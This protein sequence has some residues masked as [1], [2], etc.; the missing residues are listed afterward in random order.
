M[1]M[2]TEIPAAAPCLDT[3][4]WWTPQNLCTERTL[5]WWSAQENVK[6]INSFLLDCFATQ[7]SH[8]KKKNWTSACPFELLSYPAE[9]N[10]HSVRVHGLTIPV[11][12]RIFPFQGRYFRTRSF[13]SAWPTLNGDIVQRIPLGLKKSFMCINN[14]AQI[15]TT[16]AAWSRHGRHSSQLISTLALSSNCACKDMSKYSHMTI[17][18]VAGLSPI[19]SRRFLRVFVDRVRAGKHDTTII[20]IWSQRWVKAII[21]NEDAVWKSYE[22]IVLPSRSSGN[23]LRSMWHWAVLSVVHVSTNK[24]NNYTKPRIKDKLFIMH[25]AEIVLVN[26]LIGSMAYCGQQIIGCTWL[27]YAQISTSRFSGAFCD[28]KRESFLERG[29]AS[30]KLNGQQPQRYRP[31]RFTLLETF[32]VARSSKY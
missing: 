31:P 4:V 16:T 8:P 1:T 22:A 30:P 19:P 5:K 15:C 23:P 29:K 14:T 17:V 12:P 13:L 26:V 28:I 9:T 11:G 6:W 7:R 25:L 10:N 3:L 20:W 24:T 21:Q 2:D 32:I 27:H 18:R